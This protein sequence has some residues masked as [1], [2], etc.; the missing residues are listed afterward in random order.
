L[1]S[2]TS[3]G[4]I[5]NIMSRARGIEID[6][7]VI[8]IAV[9]VATLLLF[10]LVAFTSGGVRVAFGLLFAL[11][12]PG[13]ALISAL[14]PR[15]GR[16]GGIERIALSFGLSIAI[17]PLIGFILNFTPWGIEL[18]PIVISITIFILATS[19][20]GWYRQRKLEPAQRFKVVLKG[21]S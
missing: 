16:L 1:P 8:L 5:P 3:L 7:Q 9:V 10:P 20:V 17:V 12:F 19:V 2:Q 13:Y 21:P 15:Q 14:F 6:N 4:I 18:Y 11:F